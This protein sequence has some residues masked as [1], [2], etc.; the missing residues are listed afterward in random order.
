MTTSDGAR[1]AETSCERCEGSGARPAC[2]QEG[3]WLAKWRVPALCRL[4]DGSVAP[5]S[6]DIGG[7]RTALVE[8]S[9]HRVPRLVRALLAAGADPNRIFRD[10][11]ASG[12][13]DDEERA[14]A[15]GE[16][17]AA[18]DRETFDTLLAAG[19]DVGLTGKAGYQALHEAC[20]RGRVEMCRELLNR[21][22]D[23]AALTDLGE[24]PTALARSGIGSASQKSEIIELLASA[25]HDGAAARRPALGRSS[26]GEHRRGY[27]GWRA[28]ARGSPTWAF[29]AVQASQDAL[30]REVVRLHRDL[31]WE[32]DVGRGPCAANGV[33]LVTLGQAGHEWT[34]LPSTEPEAG[35]LET[36]VR[37]ACASLATRGLVA[38]QDALV[39]IS[40]GQIEE[41]TAEEHGPRALTA[42]AKRPDVVAV[43]VPVATVLSDGTWLKVEVNVASTEAIRV[44]V[45]RRGRS[46]ALARD[47]ARSP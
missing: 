22:A 45:F 38:L 42:A 36:T 24:S 43:D 7:P 17:V 26:I 21:G 8:M 9:W 4:L 13:I 31:E 2:D 25:L 40:G 20:T 11:I 41:I 5:D 27:S 34:L 19:A 47:P 46:L 15:L 44:D 39:V 33:E 23:A 14:T 29:G 3:R 1:A 35:V 6:L 28:A 12:S 30:A 18:G 37:G 10:G 32:R 16:A